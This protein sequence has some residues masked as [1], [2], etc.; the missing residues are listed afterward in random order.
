MIK[1]VILY[2]ILRKNLSESRDLKSHQNEIVLL[3][4]YLSNTFKNHFLIATPIFNEA[5]KDCYTNKLIEKGESTCL[6]RRVVL[7]HTFNKNLDYL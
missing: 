7:I 3:N 2:L 6:R 1:F 5:V 4:D